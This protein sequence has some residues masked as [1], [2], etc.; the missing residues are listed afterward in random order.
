MSIYGI[1]GWVCT[2]VWPFP[3]PVMACAHPLI[4][5]CPQKGESKKK[6]GRIT[7]QKCHFA[8]IVNFVHQPEGKKKNRQPYADS[9]LAGHQ[10]CQ[11]WGTGRAVAQIPRVQGGGIHCFGQGTFIVGVVCLHNQNLALLAT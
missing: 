8:N 9:E 3:L 10:T 7:W 5:V 2:I 4:S 6:K 1:N 11:P